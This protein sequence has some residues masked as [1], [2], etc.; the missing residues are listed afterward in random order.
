MGSK[1]MKPMWM[2]NFGLR[3]KYIMPKVYEIAGSL[4][5][6]SG[7][8]AGVSG[9]VDD[10]DP[11]KIAIGAVLYTA[12]KHVYRKNVYRKSSLENRIQ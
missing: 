12:G 11:I 6:Y 7:I 5:E 1:M 3:K 4:A 10:C 2:I 8:A 9:I